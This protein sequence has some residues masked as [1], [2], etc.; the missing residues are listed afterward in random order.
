M[1]NA[2]PLRYPGGKWRFANYFGRLI[3]INFPAP[4]LYFEPYAGGASLALSL[5]FRGVVSKVYLNDLDRSV[6]SF[7]RTVVENTD[8]LID[9][10]QSTPI[11]PAEWK[12]QHTV[13]SQESRSAR[14]QRAFAFFFL[15][16]TN[17]SGILN[18]GMIGGKQQSGRWKLDA[19][20]NREELIR[21]IRTIRTLK[22][23]IHISREDGIDFARQQAE[24]AEPSIMYVDPPYFRSG[25]RLYMNFYGPSEHI[26]LRDT[27]RK[28]SCAWVVSYDDVPEIRQLYRGIKSRRFALL[29]TARSARLGKEVMFFEPSLKVPRSNDPI[30]TITKTR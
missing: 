10:I 12:K 25:Q 9:L 16:R 30:C 4:P 1:R 7:W 15:N 19:R 17:H 13:Y 29:H 11:T 20:Y 28:L 18:A 5:L 21:R 8:E 27:L 24:H 23:R 3:S 6:Y 2:S 14:V 22:S 26:A